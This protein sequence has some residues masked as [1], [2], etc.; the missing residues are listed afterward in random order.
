MFVLIRSA[1]RVRCHLSPD[2]LVVRQRV[3]L[4]VEAG[5]SQAPRHDHDQDE[6]TETEQ[7]Q[8]ADSW[9]P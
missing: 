8:R 1:G 9:P 2:R 6:E 3:E 7:Q 5:A 4:R